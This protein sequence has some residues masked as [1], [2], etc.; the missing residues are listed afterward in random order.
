MI[1]TK[2][3]ELLSF[4]GDQT[5]GPGALNGRLRYI[6]ENERGDYELLNAPPAKYYCSGILFPEKVQDES[7]PPLED[8]EREDVDAEDFSG[9]GENP[10]AMI[11]DDIV[12]G[13]QTFPANMGI[14]VAISEDCQWSD[15]KVQLSFR[16]YHKLSAKEAAE[17]VCVR[18]AMESKDFEELFELYQLTDVLEVITKG[19]I[20]YVRYCISGDHANRLIAIASGGDHIFRDRLID[21]LKLDDPELNDLTIN[22]IKARIMRAQRQDQ[23]NPQLISC[24]N[25]INRYVQFR[26]H[27]QTLIDLW[28]K[29]VWVGKDMLIDAPISKRELFLPPGE[30]SI[31]LNKEEPLIIYHADDARLNINYL[32]TVDRRNA[33]NKTKYLKIQL[34]NTSERVE[35]DLER[36]YSVDNRE[37]N[38]KSFFGI[39]I[40]VQSEKLIPYNHT[41]KNIVDPEDVQNKYIYREFQSFGTG[42]G[43]SIKWDERNKTV[44]STYLPFYSSPEVETI[45]RIK[46]LI[47]SSNDNEHFQAVPF[48]EDDSFLQIQRLSTF[49][50]NDVV[51]DS[52]STLVKGYDAWIQQ[53]KDLIPSSENPQLH[54]KIVENCEGDSHRLHKN[55]ELLKSDPR[56]LLI[57]RYMNSAMLMQ[58]LHGKNVLELPRRSSYTIDFYSTE[59]F[60]IN[61]QPPKWRPFQLAFILL[62]LDG[63]FTPS[64]ESRAAVDLIWFPTGGGK[65]EAYLS[66]I[67]LTVMY[68]RIFHLEN[69]AGTAVIMR[70]TLRLLALQQFQ[71]ATLLIMA[72]ELLRRWELS[73]LPLGPVPITI[74]LWTGVGL[75][76]NSF[77]QL[78]KQIGDIM[79]QV[80][81]ITPEQ[82][83]PRI[84]DL[85]HQKCPWCNTPLVLRQDGLSSLNYYYDSSEKRSFLYCVNKNCIFSKEIG[86]ENSEPLPIITC[87]EEIYL[88]PPSLLFGTVDKF[89]ALAHRI[90]DDLHND[91]RRLFGNRYSNWGAVKVPIPP[92]MI[93]QDE[94]HLISGPL[95][96]STALVETAIQELCVRTDQHGTF[97]AKIISSTATIRNSREQVLELYGRPVNLFPKPGPEADDSFFAFY[98]RS[99]TAKDPKNFEFV[100]KRGYLGF[101]PTGRSQMWTQLRLTALCLVHR[102][103][104][105]KKNRISPPSESFA[106][107]LDYYHTVLS[108]FNSLK[109][110]GKTDSQVNTYL[111]QE[112][113]RVYK[114]LFY[115]DWIAEVNYTEKINKSE[116]TGRLSGEE[117]KTSLL[118]I[119]KNIDVDSLRSRGSSPP[120][121]VMATNMISVGLDISRLNTMIVN[122]MPRSISEYIQATSRVAR[123][124]PGLVLTVHHPYRNRDVSHFEKFLEFHQTFYGRVEPIS[125]TPRARKTLD[126][127]LSLYIAILSRHHFPE[128]AINKSVT[129]ISDA[130]IN[131][132]LRSYLKQVVNSKNFPN[133]DKVIF[134]QWI[135]E[136]IDQWSTWVTSNSDISLVFEYLN[137]MKTTEQQKLYQ[138]PYSDRSNILQERWRVPHSLRSVEEGTVINIKPL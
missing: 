76:S 130:K 123:E 100:S 15:V 37:V 96:S 53:K 121:F 26:G 111:E 113:R 109:E 84:K 59:T 68:R 39:T 86:K 48:F 55:L 25:M 17:Q 106:K 132:G 31:H 27:L 104:F 33:A 116:L 75:T 21:H 34:L 2:K 56:Y 10:A 64:A 108:Y 82:D 3:N 118:A 7:I 20:Q 63:I 69:G 81:S 93:I 49:H 87:D 23:K 124:H 65:T 92:D 16:K 77:Q 4:I 72:L 105:D 40:K 67:A 66:L 117:V 133:T 88:R 135:D 91:S 46:S 101:L 110:L 47:I 83:T 79:E 52:L 102:I 138:N 112:V 45:P 119:E 8:A 80:Q 11:T 73:D 107:A 134:E 115:T 103:V 30:F 120:D 18:I 114:N 122:G 95:G 71:R 43:C 19:D 127:F 89:A 57:F 85:T 29:D 36:F 94:L 51:I 14:T 58:M 70:Y 5:I 28:R 38:S 62:N 128:L 41:I 131:L 13:N 24:L 74:G 129:N 22:Q 32:L 9:E 99:Y 125:I 136:A 50:K 6:N 97:G 60:T 44:S 61:G 54:Q 42:H 78:R 126:K 35:E 98:K 12:T 90:S 137:P 1:Q